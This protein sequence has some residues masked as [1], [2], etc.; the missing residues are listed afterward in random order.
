MSL[1]SQERES[2]AQ[3]LVNPPDPS[4][5]YVIPP[6]IQGLNRASIEGRADVMRNQNAAIARFNRVPAGP[7]VTE[8]EAPATQETSTSGGKNKKSKKGKKSKQNK[9]GKKSKQSKKIKSRR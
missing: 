7:T 3:M 8:Q 6:D 5:P 4:N 9:K 2:K 1:S